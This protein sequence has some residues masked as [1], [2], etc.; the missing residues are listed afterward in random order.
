MVLWTQAREVERHPANARSPWR[1]SPEP[2]HPA[3]RA[4][5]KPQV[6]LKQ[7]IMHY[8]TNRTPCGSRSALASKL[9]VLKQA[10][11]DP[12]SFH[13]LPTPLARELYEYSHVVELLPGEETRRDDAHHES[14]ENRREPP[15]DARSCCLY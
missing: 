10:R 13:H 8:V 3:R 11:L 4:T 9:Q 12:W 6:H 5:R 7:Q 14:P 15:G 1:S 2:P